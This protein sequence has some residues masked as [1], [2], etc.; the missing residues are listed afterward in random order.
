MR[1][2]LRKYTTRDLDIEYVQ[3]QLTRTLLSHIITKYSQYKT[4]IYEFH[5]IIE[6]LLMT[7]CNS[8]CKTRMCPPWT[9]YYYVTRTDSFILQM[10]AELVQKCGVEPFADDIVEHV[11]NTI[12]TFV[13]SDPYVYDEKEVIKIYKHRLSY[14]AFNIELPSIQ[15]AKLKRYPRVIMMVMVMRYCAIV[16]KSQQWS[17]PDTMFRVLYDKYNVRFEAFSSPIN[18]TLCRYKNTGYCS[19]F[20]IDQHFGSM[21]SIFDTDM[22]NPISG[23]KLENIGWVVHPPYIMETMVM[24]F[25]RIKECI[26]NAML[27]GISTFIVFVIPYIPDSRLYKLIK[28]THFK[29]TEIVMSRHTHFY[30]NHGRYI[31]SSFDTAVFIFDESADRF[32]DNYS[33]IVDAIYIKNMPS[34]INIPRIT[35]EFIK[36]SNYDTIVIHDNDDDTNRVTM[37]MPSTNTIAWKMRY[38]DVNDNFVVTTKDISPMIVKTV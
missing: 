18:N 7:M 11:V 26:S 4:S 30:E 14:R 27:K 6:R 20:D 24:A 15:I 5:N 8:L 37:K 29:Y 28:K 23:V 12:N 33:D 10:R 13:A 22:A 2:S 38:D 16:I 3:W 31:N 19:M 36:E 21:G 34:N 17:L 1:R 25:E 35:R 9:V 32:P